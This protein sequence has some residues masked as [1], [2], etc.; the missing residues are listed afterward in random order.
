MPYAGVTKIR[1]DLNRFQHKPNGIQQ[2]KLETVRLSFSGM[3]ETGC[4]SQL[5]PSGEAPILATVH[6][7][8]ESLVCGD[9]HDY[10]FF[11]AF[12]LVVH[13]IETGGLPTWKSFG[14]L[15]PVSNQPQDR[16][17]AGSCWAH[18]ETF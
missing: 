17:T 16:V 15:Q 10:G 13:C 12:R 14:L 1:G 3:F 9:Y 7:I 2:L 4:E 6:D 8:P 5:L 11:V 18:V